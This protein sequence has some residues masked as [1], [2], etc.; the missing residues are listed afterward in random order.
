MDRRARIGTPRAEKIECLTRKCHPSGTADRRVRCADRPGPASVRTAHRRR[1]WFAGTSGPC[2]SSILLVLA[3][4]LADGGQPA[5]GQPAGPLRA[6]VEV[7]PRSAYVGQ[8]VDMTVSVV[9]RTDPSTVATPLVDWAE[10]RPGM[11]D[12]APVSGRDGSSG[13]QRFVTHFQVIPRR[14][15]A[16]TIPAIEVKLGDRVGRTG[17]MRLNVQSPPTTGRTAEFLGGVGAFELEARVDRSTVRLG[18]TLEYV[19]VVKG[20]GSVGINAGPN[21]ER[22]GKSSVPIEIE[23]RPDQ[24]VV[25]P[26]SHAFVFQLRPTRAGDVTLPPIRVSGFDPEPGRYLT[27]ASPSVSLRVVDVPRLDPSTLTYGPAISAAIDHSETWRIAAAT[28]AL[29]TLGLSGSAVAVWRARSRQGVGLASKIAQIVK[30][31]EQSADASESGRAITE[32]LVTYLGLAID[33]PEGALTPDEAAH[34]IACATGSSSLAE[35]AR[36]LIA[37]CDQAQ[38][39]M[40]RPKSDDLRALG[41][42]FF[43]DLPTSPGTGAGETQ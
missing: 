29:V 30:R 32:G 17:P 8:A 35:R 31:I 21:V 3:A 37:E 25:D 13:L 40:S 5:F 19:L 14:A 1:Q 42:R 43:V 27:R 23:R 7:K 34:G 6:T 22:L 11:I 16:R 18:Q 12:R 39:G 26:P 10:V 20:L 38:F 36:G 4:I 9:G 41:C 28:I 24:V 33:R 15:G 2:R